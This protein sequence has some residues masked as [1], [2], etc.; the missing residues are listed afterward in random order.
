LQSRHII[1]VIIA[2]I[3]IIIIGLDFAYEQKHAIAV[4]LS[5]ASHQHD[6]LQFHPFSCK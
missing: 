6:D 2:V 3:I 1:T 4:F 5:L